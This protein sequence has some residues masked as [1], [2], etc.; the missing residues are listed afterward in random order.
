LFAGSRPYGGDDVV[1]GSTDESGHLDDGGRHGRE[2]NP[3]RCHGAIRG[4]RDRCG[5]THDRDL[6]R[7]P[8]FEADIG[9]RGTCRRV[10]DVDRD[11]Q[12]VGGCNGAA[13][14]GPELADRY[15]PAAVQRQQLDFGAEHE[16][17]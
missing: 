10:G 8:I 9:A 14:P 12:F 13:R 16:Q 6:H 7:S 5:G 15:A 1:D 17:R 11:A 3:Q 2:R 4:E